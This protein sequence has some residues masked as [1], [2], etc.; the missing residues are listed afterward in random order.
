MNA[1]VY[2]SENGHTAQ[3]AKILSEKTDLPAFELKEALKKLD[4]GTSVIYLGWLFANHIKGYKKATKSFQIA[5]IGAVGLCDTGT[6]I[7]VVRKAN[8][9][10]ETVPLF[11]MQGGMDK[12]K[13]HGVNKFM[14][15]M[16]TK[17]FESKQ[18][19]TSD[20]ERILYLLNNDANYVCEENAA[21]FMKWYLSQKN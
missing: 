19:R 20:E 3:Y 8:S 16:L 18:N 10:S 15:K 13:L 4:K 12:T 9:L 2:T 5:A 21:Q 6:A 7:S 17:S 14:I 11:T 1:I